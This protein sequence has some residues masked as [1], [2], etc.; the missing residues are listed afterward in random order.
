MDVNEK[1]LWEIFNSLGVPHN[2]FILREI[3]ESSTPE[4]INKYF[5]ILGQTFYNRSKLRATQDMPL[6]FS[7]MVYFNI[8]MR[9]NPILNVFLE[10]THLLI[11]IY[12][13]T[14][15][16]PNFFIT[17]ILIPLM[18]KGVNLD[19]PSSKMPGIPLLKFLEEI[20]EEGSQ[21][22]EIF[23][24]IPKHYSSK[25]ATFLFASLNN[26]ERQNEILIL[27]DTPEFFYDRFKYELKTDCIQMQSIKIF[28]E[29]ENL[30]LIMGDEFI[31]TDSQLLHEHN[32]ALIYYNYEV[33][34]LRFDVSDLPHYES[35]N[36]LC[37]AIN[38]NYSHLTR[39]KDFIMLA[40]RKDIYLCQHFFDRLPDSWR[41]EAINIYRTPR[42]KSMTLTIAHH[43]CFQ[44]GINFVSIEESIK[45]VHNL[46]INTIG[47]NRR[48]EKIKQLESQNRVYYKLKHNT[49]DDLLD[50]D[51]NLCGVSFANTETL[52]MDNVFLLNREE[53]FSFREG[54]HIYFFNV[55]GVNNLI[56][57]K[58]NPYNQ[59]VVGSQLLEKARVFLNR[60]SNWLKDCKPKPLDEILDEIHYGRSFVEGCSCTDQRAVKRL[61]DLLKFRN[62]SEQ[63]LSNLHIGDLVFKMSMMGYSIPRSTDPDLIF[64]EI[65]KLI[66]NSPADKKE[67]I[68]KHISSII[69][70]Q[71]I[72]LEDQTRIF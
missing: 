49:I 50:N 46:M 16:Y 62:I 33:L 65:C 61:A 11:W 42:W 71:R 32:H 27:M 10:D 63:T 8:M 29:I 34:K 15:P 53:V 44:L 64:G 6:V 23:A 21:H 41:Q 45:R 35:L 19:F 4:Q 52:S 25:H 37:R 3:L 12:K 7:L 57:K 1:C 48:E 30:E 5:E 26:K 22:K 17:F 20:S 2:I 72:P 38:N 67:I 24:H 36:N 39:V 56:E 40:L 43:Y 69:N 9:Y 59:V 60:H 18:L 28:R 58:R 68:K 47:A 51:L 14:F 66:E 13:A 31:K 55:D 70:I 54:N